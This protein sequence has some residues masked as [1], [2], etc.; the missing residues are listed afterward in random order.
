MKRFYALTNKNARFAWQIARLQ[1][2]QQYLNREGPYEHPPKKAKKR[3]RARYV[4]VP[5]RAPLQVPF[6]VE[7]PLAPCSPKEHTQISEEQSSSIHIRKLITQNRD[8]PSFTNFRALLDTHIFQ[9]LEA[10]EGRPTTC[11]PTTEERRMIRIDKDTLWLH[12]VM[13]INWTSYDMRREQSSINPRTHPDI[14][15]RAPDGSSHPYLYARV[16]S[17]FHVNVLRADPGPA[18]EQTEP[19]LLQILWVRWFDLDTSCP[20]GFEH[21]RPHRLKFAALEDEPFGFISP[22]QVLRDVHIVPAPKY[23]LSESPS[24]PYRVVERTNKR[25]TPGTPDESAE[26]PHKD[27]YNYY[28]IAM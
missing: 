10:L 8:D 11:S 25:T 1:R 24:L 4:R 13:R 20:G 18:A 21:F 9:R 6:A 3:P 22:Q 23:G 14:M 19:Q 26:E 5:L 15:M 27:E 16:V 7:E 2:R 17:I 12:K 28:Y